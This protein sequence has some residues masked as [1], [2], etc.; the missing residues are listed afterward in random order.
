MIRSFEGLRGIAALFVVLH[1]MFCAPPRPLFVNA[2]LAVDLFF[3]LSGFVICRASAAQ[4]TSWRS[5]RAFI[6]RRIGRLW[7]THI[8]TT[9]LAL[10]VV[11]HFPSAGEALA[12]ATMSHG[13]I[14]FFAGIGNAVSWSA[15]D[16]MYVYL[17]FGATCLLMRGN[18]LVIAFAMLALSACTL[19]VWMEI[20]RA[21]L[22]H[23]GCLNGLVYKFGWIRCLTG[24]F[25]GALVYEFRD[26]AVTLMNG[27]VFQVSAL[28][29]SLFLLIA[30]DAAPGSALA[31]PLVF[32]VLIGSLIRDRGPVAS[33]M[34]KPAAQYLGKISYP[35]YL[36]HGVLLSVTVNIPENAGLMA[37]IATY[38]LFLFWS[39]GIAHLLHKYIEVPSRNRF[40]AWSQTF[41]HTD[42]LTHSSETTRQQIFK[43][44]GTHQPRAQQ[45][46]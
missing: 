23:G 35:L 13:V 36:G 8:A 44:V 29:A 41:S 46:R 3:V 39:F 38:A 32:A 10:A 19:A 27:P 21:C 5:L 15:G 40:N 22:L 18:A 31:A 12:L 43:P 17:I 7:P 20:S 11:R 2:Y 4:L 16:E 14:P 9:L 37:R 25:L 42:A 6:I 28:S 34:Q 1:H 30:A 45:D 26:R 33:L 24:F